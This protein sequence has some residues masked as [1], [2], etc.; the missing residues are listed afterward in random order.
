MPSGG[1]RRVL[2]AAERKRTGFNG[3]AV[4]GFT[5]LSVGCC[6]AGPLLAGLVGGIGLGAVLGGG[7]GLIALVA[8]STAV[9]ARRRLRRCNSVIDR[10]SRQ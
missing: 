9:V 10:R 2:M 4:G 6:S 1:R 5:V 3:L 7:V 8:L